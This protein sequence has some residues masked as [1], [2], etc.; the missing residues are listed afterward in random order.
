MRDACVPLTVFC[1]FFFSLLPLLLLLLLR[2]IRM[3]VCVNAYINKCERLTCIN[4][5]VRLRLIRHF[6]S[7]SLC[8]CA[9]F[10]QLDKFKVDASSTAF[11]AC[12]CM[13]A[14]ILHISFDRWHSKHFKVRETTNLFFSSNFQLNIGF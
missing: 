9:K 3:C 5:C 10:V 14:F 7:V 4:L 2:S 12:I 11:T 1:C 6:S 8:E 13:R